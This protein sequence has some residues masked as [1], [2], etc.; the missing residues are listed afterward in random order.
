MDNIEQIRRMLNKANILNMGL[1]DISMVIVDKIYKGDFDTIIELVTKHREFYDIAPYI[2]RTIAKTGR[3]E[4][5]SKYNI[6]V[7]AW[8]DVFYKEFE[9]RELLSKL[10]PFISRGPILKGMEYRGRYKIKEK[11][12]VF[13]NIENSYKVFEN[14]R[15]DELDFTGYNFDKVSR[16]IGTFS[17]CYIN[18]VIFKDNEFSLGEI[19]LTA[20]Q[21]GVKAIRFKDCV[22]K[23]DIKIT[24][25]NPSVEFDNCIFNGMTRITM[26][27]HEE[28][29]IEIKVGIKNCK[30]IGSLHIKSSGRTIRV[31][32]NNMEF[33]NGIVDYKI[34]DCII[35]S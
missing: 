15:V 23:H 34:K 3:E 9:N 21:V 18:E 30:F 1:K 16:M 13:D 32:K 14:Y 12:L 10:S 20:E 8:G 5:L 4:E 31:R 29:A 26:L 25:Y 11:G 35:H 19:Y 17:N 28:D 2:C 33:S 22:F 7:T 27:N 6:S 24:L